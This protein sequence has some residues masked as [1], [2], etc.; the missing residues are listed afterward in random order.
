ML[1]WFRDMHK[2]RQRLRHTIYEN[3]SLLINNEK[4]GVK[5][6]DDRSKKGDVV[7]HKHARLAHPAGQLGNFL[8]QQ[9][10][11]RFTVKGSCEICGENPSPALCQACA[12]NPNSL[13]ILNSRIKKV[14]I[15]NN[16]LQHICGNCVKH[17]QIGSIFTKNEFIGKD[18]CESIDCQIFYE[19]CRLITKIEDCKEA[20]DELENNRLLQ[21]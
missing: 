13:I 21:W 7:N 20:I 9:S 14:E 10:M 1:A 5:S 4:N 3:Y 11:D 19:R 17:S 2:P 8:K 18:C 6:N 15:A 12:N 16:E